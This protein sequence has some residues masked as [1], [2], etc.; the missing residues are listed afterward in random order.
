MHKKMMPFLASIGEMGLPH[1]IFFKIF[2]WAFQGCWGQM[3]MD[4]EF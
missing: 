4:V 3:T 1:D 2:T